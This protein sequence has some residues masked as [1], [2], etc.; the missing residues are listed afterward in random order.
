VRSEGLR[1]WKNPMTPSGIE[2]AT[3]RFV[4]QYLNH[5][6]TAVPCPLKKCFQNSSE[7]SKMRF[8]IFRLNEIKARNMRPL[9][10][11]NNNN[12]NNIQLATQ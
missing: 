6:A 11:N 9:K 10:N 12:N 4:A 8:E 3:F 5:C 2:P 1:Q 7:E